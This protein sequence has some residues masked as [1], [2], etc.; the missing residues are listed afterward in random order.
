MTLVSVEGEGDGAAGAIVSDRH[1]AQ[2][3]A[4]QG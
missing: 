4:Q 1:P 3:C 2:S